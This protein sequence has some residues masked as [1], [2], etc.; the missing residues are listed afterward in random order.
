MKS[1]LQKKLAKGSNLYSQEKN[2]DLNQSVCDG[3][4]ASENRPRSIA[5]NS[6]QRCIPVSCKEKLSFE[7]WQRR[8][9]SSLP[10]ANRNPAVSYN[11]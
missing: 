7:T 11:S 1:L 5:I 6:T 4:A 10:V 9:K 8:R 2:T 3:M